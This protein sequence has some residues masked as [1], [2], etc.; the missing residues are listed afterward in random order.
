MEI[1][2]YHLTGTRPQQGVL[3]VQVKVEGVQF[4][5]DEVGFVPSSGRFAGGGGASLAQMQS[6]RQSL[7]QQVQQ[8][9]SY[10]HDPA[11][12]TRARRVEKMLGGRDWQTATDHGQKSL[13]DD[14]FMAL[15]VD[16]DVASSLATIFVAHRVKLVEALERGTPGVGKDGK[17]LGPAPWD[18]VNESRLCKNSVGWAVPPV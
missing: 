18:V 8:K 1:L 16:V 17:A 14:E 6:I 2:A 11:Q 9:H 10:V 13:D 3:G 15:L 12:M 7:F 5:V 4:D